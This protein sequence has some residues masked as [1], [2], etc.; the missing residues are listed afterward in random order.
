MTPALLDLRPTHAALLRAVAHDGSV[1]SLARSL[2]WSPAQVHQYLT[3]LAGWGLVR[4]TDR[5]WLVTPTGQ[6]VTRGLTH[7]EAAYVRETTGE[8]ENRPS[9]A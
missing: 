6:A 2:G 8:V 4:S 3:R 7:A 1:R 5:T 9:R